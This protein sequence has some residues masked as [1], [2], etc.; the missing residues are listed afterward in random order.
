MSATL[1]RRMGQ[2]EQ[3]VQRASEPEKRR[4]SVLLAQPAPEA[5]AETQA[6]FQADKDAAIKRGD[7]VILLV[8]LRSSAAADDRANVKAAHD[9]DDA[10]QEVPERMPPGRSGAGRS[11]IP[12]L[13][14]DLSGKVVRPVEDDE[15]AAKSRSWRRG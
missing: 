14:G 10:A 6:K 4:N 5:S 2:L 9:E 7:M 8:G 15:V 11:A 12:D 3:V 1:K 13:L